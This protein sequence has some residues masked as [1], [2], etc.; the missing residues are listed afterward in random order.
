[1][2]IRRCLYCYKELQ[3]FSVEFHSACSKKIFGKAMLPDW[4]FSEKDIQELALKSIKNKWAVTG[5]QAKLSLH[6]LS[7]NNDIENSRFT[8]VGM[9]GDYI[10][11][12]PTIQYEQLPEVEDLTMHLASLVKIEV[13]PHTL[14]RLKSGELAYLTKRIDRTKKTRLAMEDMCQ[15]T[16][17]LTEDKYK[18]SYEQVANAILKYSS[19]PGLDLVNFFEQVLFAFLTGNADMH[20]KNYSL[21]EF[22][23]QGYV[24]SPA[25]D[26]VSTYLVNPEDDEELA[27]TLR[28]KKKKINKEDFLEI[29]RLFKLDSKQQEN[30][31]KKFD[32]VKE[33]W[34]SF[35]DKSFV[36]ENLKERY[37]KLIYER[38]QRL[39]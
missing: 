33:E 7:N 6:L 39:E 29:F 4:E 17:R 13:V 26:L 34:I 27:L 3:D 10:L 14:I 9:W 30:I 21:I 1:M 18:G 15:L 25:Y 24:L 37:R 36:S 28:G 8:I 35:I 12:L 22:S 23:N 19:N 38:F 20:L 16:N 2:K 11:K 32:A 31:F 5:V